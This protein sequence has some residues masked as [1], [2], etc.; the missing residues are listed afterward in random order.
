L[1]INSVVLADFEQLQVVHLNVNPLVL[2]LVSAG[3]SA[4]TGQVI[5][6][7]K[8]LSPLVQDIAKAVIKD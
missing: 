5:D 4:N 8:S 6:F 2:T 7:A 1:G 3:G